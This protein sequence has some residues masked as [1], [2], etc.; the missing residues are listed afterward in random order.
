MGVMR[1]KISPPP[2]LEE[3][4][5]AEQTCISGLDGRV[6]PTQVELEGDILSCRRPTSESGKLHV[7]WNVEGFGVPVLSTAS[8]MERDEEYILAVEL[9]RG[10]ISQVRDQRAAWEMSG[11]HIPDELAPLMKEAHQHFSKA[12]TQ[13]KNPE[14]ACEA[15]NLAIERACEAADVLVTSYTKQR[16]AVRRKRFPQLP[17]SLGCRLGQGVP[18]ETTARQFT[19]AFNS[20]IVPIEWSQIEPDEGEYNWD[21]LDAQVAWCQD[22]K[23]LTIG[24]P[25]CSLSPGGMPGWLEQW[26]N[27]FYNLQ[28]FVS[29]F[30]ET[31]ISR[32]VGRI[33]HWQVCAA[34]N[35]GGCFELNEE[36]RLSLVARTLEVARQVDEEI[37]LIIN[38]DQPWGE[39]QANGQHQLSPLQFV[40]ALVR[41]GVGL[42]GVNLEYAVGFLPN[43]TSSREMLEFSHLLDKWSTLGIPLHVTL[44]FPSS[45]STDDKASG[46]LSVNR[47]IWRK[48]WSEKSQKKW[49]ERQLP[50]LMAKQ[51]V[52]GI[53]WTHFSDAEPHRYPH[54]GLVD[55]DENSKAALERIT[56][57]RKFYWRSGE[58]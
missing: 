40:D 46:R 4:P 50:V 51:P 11:M 8:L 48:A 57:Y 21:T 3:W 6:F 34:A 32:Y 54:A 24:G 26:K 55:I 1:F 29:D 23:L 41:S 42:S 7:P 52:V 2:N 45:D 14:A 53:Y 10:R 37:Q 38:V 36:Q 18:D 13:Q 25:L 22:Q 39:Y 43:R 28:S 44:A 9:A 35:I 12:V 49:V 5:E 19:E 58:E 15:A 17:A 47:P 56:R 20:A 33:R 30:V 31:A 16:L 27:D